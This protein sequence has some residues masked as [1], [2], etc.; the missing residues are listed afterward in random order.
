MS[1]LARYFVAS[2]FRLF[3]ATLAVSTLAIVVVEMLVN[4]DKIFGT[5]GFGD[6]AAPAIWSVVSYLFLRIPSYYLRD[7]IPIS[8]FSAAFLCMGLPARRSEITAAR[9][10]GISPR[11]LALPVLMA[12]MVVSGLS[13]AVNETLVQEATRRWS[14]L[15][16]GG[17]RITYRQG[18]F[19]YR[20]G[21]RIYNVAEADPDTRRLRGVRVFELDPGGRLLRAI[22]AGSVQVLAGERWEFSKPVVHSFRANRPD[23]GPRIELL[24][25]LNLEVGSQRDL[26]LL[27]SQASGLGL[28]D[29]FDAIAAKREAGR[30]VRRE[31]AL[32]QRRLS[33]P[34]AC[35]LLAL[36]AIPVGFGV[37][38]SRNLAVS[39]LWGICWLAAFQATR[40]TG[41]LIVSATTPIATLLPWLTL[42]LFSALG[43]R[44]L[45]KVPR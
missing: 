15:G 17:E 42:A 38:R 4:F 11:R 30:S 25:S 14:R 43:T 12:A 44:Q 9:A 27:S 19:W 41:N 21:D 33:E 1:I 39:A 8:S 3:V 29:L 31:L 22:R 23:L 34:L 28:A 35:L 16:I 20:R 6:A 26:Q 24:P 36:L 7:L 32:L 2:Y 10:G 5:R 37:E 18:T 13:L 45:L 40:V